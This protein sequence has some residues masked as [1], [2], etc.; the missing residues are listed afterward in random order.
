LLEDSLELGNR[1]AMHPLVT[2]M[3]DAI[4]LLAPGRVF[5]ATMTGNVVVTGFAIVDVPGLSLRTSLAVLVAAAP[6]ESWSQRSAWSSRVHRAPRYRGVR[7]F[8]PTV[9]CET[10][11]RYREIFAE[12][13]IYGEQAI[14]VGRERP[15]H[16]VT[17]GLGHSAACLK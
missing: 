2:G 8:A 4:S 14:R 12:V 6:H 5:V 17:S 15:S 16:V 13:A 1:Q 7:C 9:E 10:G 3:I 11:Q